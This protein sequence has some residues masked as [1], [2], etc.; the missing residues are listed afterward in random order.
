MAKVKILDDVLINQIAAG[1]VVERPAS[2]VKELVENSI[3][4]GAKEITVV[5]NQGGASLIEVI[6][7][8]EGMSKAD[9]LTAI[10]RHGTSKISSADDLLSINTHGFRGEAIPS[11]ASISRFTLTTRSKDLRDKQGVTIE[12]VGGVLKKAH[13]QTLPVGTR[14]RVEQ[15]FYNVPARKRFLRSDRTEGALIK[16]QILDF[17]AAYPYL[18]LRLLCNGQDT[19]DIT[20]ESD[21]RKRLEQ[22]RLAG[23]EHFFISQKLQREDKIFEVSGILSEPQVCVASSAKLRLLVNG[24]SVRDRIIMRAVRDGYGAMIKAS[25]YPAGLVSMK[26]DPADVDVNVHPQ[27]AEVRFRSPEAVYQLVTRG[28][29]NALSENQSGISRSESLPLENFPGS[30]FNFREASTAIGQM[31]VRERPFFYEGIPKD[32]SGTDLKPGFFDLIPKD[33]NANESS[34]KQEWSAPIEKDATKVSLDVASLRFVGQVLSCYLIFEGA[35]QFLIVD[36]HAA[37]ERVTF[38]RFKQQFAEGSVEIQRLLI[39]EEINIEDQDYESWLNAR[40]IVQRLG[41]ECQEQ[42][43]NK[44]MISGAPAILGSGD[45]QALF[46]DLLSLPFWRN[47]ISLLDRQLDDII[48]R[49]ACFGSVR[50]GR[51]LQRDEALNLLNDLAQVSYGNYCPHGRPIIKFFKRLDVERMFGR[52]L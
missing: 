22:L 48:A 40:E 12:I 19:L 21:F 25:Q 30:Q 18:R 4:A 13:D 26:I 36:M 47:W 15:L 3:D 44:V 29:A 41:F 27:K 50:S 1:E 31:Q 35:D 11:I 32:N 5:I 16:S 6:D 38:E 9:A 10:E 28:V 20:P 23:K 52:V 51:I 17:A 24:R 39:P 7:D 49:L 34:V 8:G 14:I 2:V 42:D 45:M 46:R 33:E 43:G 37:H